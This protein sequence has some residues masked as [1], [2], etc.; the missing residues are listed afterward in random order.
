MNPRWMRRFVMQSCG[1]ERNFR[2]FSAGHASET[3]EI[4]TAHVCHFSRNGTRVTTHS[5]GA[6]CGAASV[7]HTQPRH[8][9]SIPTACAVEGPRES[10]ILRT[11]LFR[12]ENV[13]PGPV[14]AS[15]VPQLAPCPI[16][17]PGWRYLY[18]V[19]DQDLLE[20]ALMSGVPG[21][22]AAWV[23]RSSFGLVTLVRRR[24]QQF[25]TIPFGLLSHILSG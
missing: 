15:P 17:R 16:P 14:A 1:N 6:T 2:P 7:F 18:A 23:R 24:A 25:S 8:S 13:G 12:M 9:R 20:V 4:A 22:L 5:L 21:A 10:G 11:K 19:E 3:S